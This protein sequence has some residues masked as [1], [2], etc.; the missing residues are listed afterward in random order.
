MGNELAIWED[1]SMQER[2]TTSARATILVLLLLMGAFFV[3]MDTGTVSAAVD[4]DYTYTVSGSN[5]TITAYAGPGGAVNIPS[6]LG[7][8][9]A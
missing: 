9:P 7:S 3:V 6:T 8:S 5:A 4:G 1:D 2:R